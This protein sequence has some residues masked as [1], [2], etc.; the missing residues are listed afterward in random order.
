[1]LTDAADEPIAT[2]T[3][4]T[5]PTDIVMT[6]GTVAENATPGTVAASLSAVDADPGDT[7]TFSLVGGDTS[8]FEIQGDKVVVKS[9]ASLD[10][11]TAQ[12]HSLTVEVQDSAGNVYSEQIAIGVTDVVETMTGTNAADTLTGG[13][14]DDVLEGH[15]G[16]DMLIG[17]DGNDTLIGGTGADYLLGGAGDDTMQ[18][19]SD[20]AWSSRYAAYNDTT[21]G[22]R[23]PRRQ[24]PQL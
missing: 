4:N 18:F 6:G 11:E 2:V 3:P 7:F 14:G 9:G 17:G 10:F 23:Q 21:R 15:G 19:G 22:P 12:S 16:N 20:A 13:V 5:A 1:M 8:L 24:R